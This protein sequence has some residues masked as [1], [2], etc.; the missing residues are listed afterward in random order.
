MF[1]Y[2]YIVELLSPKSSA[3]DQIGGL[4][5]RFAERFR[6][7]IDAGCGISIPDSQG[8]ALWSALIEAAFLSIPK[9]L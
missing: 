4:L 5:D 3:D 8:W 6:R 1:D 7:I 2:S 9:R